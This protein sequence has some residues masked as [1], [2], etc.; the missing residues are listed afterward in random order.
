MRIAV[1]GSIA[2]DHLMTFPGRFTDQLLA[3][4][5]DKVSLS[6]LV[7]GM[8]VRQGGVAANIAYGLGVLGQDPVLVGGAGADFDGHRPRLKEHGVDTDAVLVSATRQTARF[9]CLTD[10]DMNQIAAFY[11]GAM[12]EAA[13]IRLGAVAEAAGGLDLVL[14]SPNDPKAMTGHTQECREL[15]IP[16]AADPSQQLASLSREQTRGLVEGAAWLF[17]NEYEAA[18]VRERTGWSERQVLER[19][20]A[21]VTTLGAQGVRIARRDTGDEVVPAVPCA[22]PVDPTGVGDAFRAGFLAGLAQRLR[23][24][25]AARLGCALATTA[26]GSTG[27]QEYTVTARDLSRALASRYG[28]AAA[29]EAGAVLERVR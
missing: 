7:D 14:V 5:L 24:G 25:A 28:D 6:F 29:A 3:D 1:T 2:I 13:D 18:L 27:P 26:L 22:A 12:A 23:P 11:P 16:F 17:T 15:G 21:W 10:Q 8:D 19:V 4:Q 20:G 9:L